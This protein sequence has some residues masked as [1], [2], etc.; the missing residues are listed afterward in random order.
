[1]GR[2]PALPAY[3]EYCDVEKNDNT[4][5]PSGIDLRTLEHS[6]LN[7]I[8][9]WH[10]IV[11]LLVY[12]IPISK[13][14]IGND[15]VIQREDYTIWMYTELCTIL[16][17][18]CIPPSVQYLMML[19][20]QPP[21]YGMMLLLGTT[22]HCVQYGRFAQTNLTLFNT[23]INGKWKLNSWITPYLLAQQVSFE[24]YFQGWF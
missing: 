13:L 15:Y 4:I 12:N 5:V 14:L 24:T 21:E 3:L 18:D 11:P 6:N 23:K 22:N 7:Q 19:G 17:V 1:M 10:C 2:A 9:T 16:S 8:T 20:Y